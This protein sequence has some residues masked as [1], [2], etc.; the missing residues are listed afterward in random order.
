MGG[1]DGGGEDGGERMGGGW[2]EQHSWVRVMVKN[3]YTLS[4]F[5]IWLSR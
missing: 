1:E 2:E 3:I 5:R 4:V